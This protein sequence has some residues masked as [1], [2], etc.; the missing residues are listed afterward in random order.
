MGRKHK[1]LPPVEA[2]YAKIASILVPEHILRDFE[3]YD[4]KDNKSCWVIEMREKEGMPSRFLM[5][6][7]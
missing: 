3:I 7:C 6:N 2:M 4:A 1:E 5:K